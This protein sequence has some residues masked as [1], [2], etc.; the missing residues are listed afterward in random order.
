MRDM[1]C[2]MA[3]NH[4]RQV[5]YD[6]ILKGFNNNLNN[7]HQ[8]NDILKMCINYALLTVDC[9]EIICLYGMP[10]LSNDEE[11]VLILPV[12]DGELFQ[13]V[14][15]KGNYFDYSDSAVVDYFLFKYRN[16]ERALSIF[17]FDISSSVNTYKSKACFHGRELSFQAKKSY[18]TDA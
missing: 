11:M 12:V 17:R 16:E 18:I 14:T 15:P 6:E 8:D 13:T 10:C 4:E 3:R 1:R 5:L 7:L 9:N 2:F